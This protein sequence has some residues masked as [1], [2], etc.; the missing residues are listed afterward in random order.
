MIEKISSDY[1]DRIRVYGAERCHKTRYYLNFL[2]ER[3]LPFIFLDVEE[4]DDFAEELRD[5]YETR[6]LNFPT[7]MIKDKKLRNPSD[8]DLE[9]WLS[10]KSR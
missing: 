4:S 8:K 2:K 1:K 3:N 7:L 6:R 10:S 5:L 9:K